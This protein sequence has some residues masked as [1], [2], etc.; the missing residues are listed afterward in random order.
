MTK[1]PRKIRSRW[2]LALLLTLC[3]GPFLISLVLYHY[4]SWMIRSTHHG[5]LIRPVI[6]VSRN[7][8]GGFD[9]FSKANI[10]EIVGRWVLVQFVT[11]KGCGTVCRKS[12]ENTRQVH[13]MLGKDLMRVRRVAVVMA[14]ISAAQANAWWI[15]HPYLLRIQSNPNLNAIATSAM[16]FPIHDGAVLI[17]DPIGNF[18]MWYPAGFDPYGLKNDLQRLLQVSRLG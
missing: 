17:M 11:P 3:L 15:G 12:L 14:E 6:P 4:R 5:I 7:E 13:L 16:G 1:A 2:I 8:F 9:E 18:M 10:T